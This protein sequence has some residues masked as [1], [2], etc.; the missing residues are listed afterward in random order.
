MSLLVACLDAEGA[1]AL[2]AGLTPT[3][4]GYTLQGGFK[5]GCYELFKVWRPQRDPNIELENDEN[6]LSRRRARARAM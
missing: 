4:I 5:F 6:G 3:A 1:S 2:L